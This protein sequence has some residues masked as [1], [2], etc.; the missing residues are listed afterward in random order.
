VAPRRSTRRR[1]SEGVEPEALPQ[2][3]LDGESSLSQQSDSSGGVDAA[4]GKPEVLL[5]A[6]PEGWE[7]RSSR[8][9]GAVYYLNLLNED[10]KV[11]AVPTAAAR[12]AVASAESG[13]AG[14]RGDDAA[15]RPTEQRRSRLRRRK[16]PADTQT[17]AEG[18][19][20][21]SQQS[22]A[23]GGIAANDGDSSYGES[24]NEDEQDISEDEKLENDDSLPE[25]DGSAASQDVDDES[26]QVRSAELNAA[27][28]AGLPK[29]QLG[30][31]GAGKGQAKLFVGGGPSPAAS[32]SNLQ[33]AEA[34]G[35]DTTDLNAAFDATLPKVQLGLMSVGKCGQAKLLL[36]GGASAVIA[37]AA[38]AAESALRLEAPAPPAQM[39][40]EAAVA[41]PKVLHP[42]FEKPK[43]GPHEEGAAAAATAGEAGVEL[44]RAEPEPREDQGAAKGAEEPKVL[45][46][47][48]DKPKAG[49]HEEGAAAVEPAAAATA[50][51]A[52]AKP[53]R[54]EPGP[55][56]HQGEAAAAEER[57]RSKEKGAAVWAAFAAKTN[58]A[59]RAKPAP[60]RGRTS[61]PGKA[62]AAPRRP[63]GG[64]SAAP[65]A[66]RFVDCP[67]CDKSVPQAN[68]DDHMDRCGIISTTG[69]D[70]EDSQGADDRAAPLAPDSAAA[71]P[72]SAG[73]LALPQSG[74]GGGGP[75][76]LAACPCCSK[77]L[78]LAYIDTH[79][80]T[81]CAGAATEAAAGA[82]VADLDA[83]VRPQ[84]LQPSP[85][86]EQQ[87]LRTAPPLGASARCLAE[88][89]GRG[90]GAGGARRGE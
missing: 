13:G 61:K 44:Q 71:A 58:F 62:A 27:F 17:E 56:E 34:Q 37:P 46:P 69:A 60:P 41:E 15:G 23:S 70:L 53:E 84:P 75:D 28:D 80:D 25:E 78:P 6:L 87:Q 67:C 39:V 29:V 24:E 40:E 63:W 31:M 50:G 83:E 86:R 5:P 90:G 47:F 21:L 49:L 77:Q 11:W 85:Q 7:A 57:R 3:E 48:F 82:G 79:L 42:F 20:S 54:V 81:E 22:D 26:S 64:A 1:D 32:S 73:G 19:G 14:Q 65:S 68:M 36:G 72:T 76:G 59:D 38:A 52:G 30:L 51:G 18:E 89:G 43:A 66:S 74:A 12:P 35:E 88:R 9:D 10:E 4:D 45:H 55:R 16:P 8:K 33:Q 2:E